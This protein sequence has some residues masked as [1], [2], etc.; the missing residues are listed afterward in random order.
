[1]KLTNKFWII[2]LMIIV[3]VLSRLLPHPY[4]FTPLMAIALFGGATFDKKWQAYLVP[5]AAYF[6]SDIFLFNNAGYYTAYLVSQ[7]FVYGGMILVT[8]MGTTL[9]QPKALSVLG[10]TL[11]GSAIFWIL[12]NFGV[13][14][15]NFFAA[16]TPNYE[17]G[18]SL[19]YVYLRALPFYNELST[20]LFAG[21]F[22]GDL[23]YSGI[24]FGLYALA[25][26]S[27]PALRYSKA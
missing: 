10:Y 24:L 25:Q 17:S 3:A 21:A 9:K 2:T 14:V 26:K 20:K 23:F 11:S 22:G 6:I 15:G 12:S 18:L 1:M 13:W 27:L 7:L 19:G 16:G 5:L 8:M 4:N